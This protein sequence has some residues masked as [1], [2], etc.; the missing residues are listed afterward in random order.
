VT[1]NCFVIADDQTYIVD[2]PIDPG[3]PL[4]KM[5]LILYCH[6]VNDGTA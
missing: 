2:A 1:S 4:R 3:K 6:K 5:Y